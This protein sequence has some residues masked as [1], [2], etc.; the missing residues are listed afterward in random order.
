MIYLPGS[1]NLYNFTINNQL[2]SQLDCIVKQ[3]A[4]LNISYI[5][6]YLISTKG[7]FS[8]FNYSSIL[9]PKSSTQ[10]TVS[11]VSRDQ[12]RSL[13]SKISNYFMKNGASNTSI[14][15]LNYA[16]VTLNALS[17]S[18]KNSDL[19]LRFL[20]TYEFTSF[21][22]STYKSVNLPI[23]SNLIEGSVNSIPRFFIKK[24]I[25]KL[26]GRKKNKTKGKPPVRSYLAFIKPHGRALLSLKWLVSDMNKMSNGSTLKNKYIHLLMTNVLRLNTQSYADKKIQTYKS[27]IAF[28]KR[29]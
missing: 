18:D 25:S 21:L 9:I 17:K 28:L 16:L 6:K 26:P 11:G 27:I 1:R 19:Y 10:K 4:D 13:L 5:R 12:R 20:S 29:K 15:S 22:N 3:H 2:K 24:H 7:V 8:R 23:V 14:R